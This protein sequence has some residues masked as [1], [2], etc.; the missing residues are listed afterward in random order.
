MQRPS[1]STLRRMTSYATLAFPSGVIMF[2]GL[3]LSTLLS[4][5]RLCKTI[6]PRDRIFAL[7]G[8]TTWSTRAQ[9]LPLGIQP[10]YQKSTRNVLRD[11]TRVMFCED[12]NLDLLGGNPLTPHLPQEWTKT[13]AW[14]SW[15]PD[16]NG[17]RNLDRA[18]FED[19]YN[20]SNGH[21]LLLAEQSTELDILCL[22]GFVISPVASLFSLPRGRF[23][24][25]PQFRDFAQ[26][27]NEWRAVQTPFE[28]PLSIELLVVTLV[29]ELL[30]FPATKSRMNIDDDRL[31]MFVNVL[32]FDSGEQPSGEQSAL[33]SEI[34]KRI[35]FASK[36]QHFF[37][38]N[39]GRVG[40]GPEFMREG[41][42]V[43]VLF[44][45]RWPFVLREEGD[46]HR[47]IGP[48][49]VRGIMD[50]EA[51]R[52]REAKGVPPRDSKIR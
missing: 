19:K 38:T 2:C 15:V 20:A 28:Q 13:S 41:D 23:K 26:A 3:P 33:V 4:T 16:W 44:G 18:M 51:V 37:H 31:K 6:D 52:E 9:K 8:V 29:R 5:T 11:A 14:L 24:G 30:G 36:G 27:I 45:G 34:F 35:W 32:K 42:N 43:V 7:L 39:D 21:P 17:R 40:V 22:E 10:D 12:D 46:T 48:C 49:Y 25:L 50:G 1:T 47:L